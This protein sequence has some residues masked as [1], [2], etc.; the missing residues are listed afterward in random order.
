MPYTLKSTGLAT[1]L[2]ICVGIDSDGTTIKD[3]VSNRTLSYVSGHT[4]TVSSATWKGTSRGYFTTSGDGSFTPYGITF[5]AP[6]INYGGSGLAAFIAFSGASAATGSTGYDY[7][8]GDSSNS[9]GLSRTSLSGP[10][11]W[12]FS[13]NPQPG[14]GAT[15]LPTN[16][17]TKFSIGSSFLA[18][19]TITIYYGL[20]SGSLASDG[21]GTDINVPSNWLPNNIGG[22]AGL[23]AQPGNY[24]IA[25]AFNRVL[26]LAEMQ[27][28]HGDGTNDWFSTLFNSG[29]ADT[30][31]GQASL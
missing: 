22:D 26:T 1:S 19:G 23:G 24:H 8:I 28:L 3:F 18:G 25:C 17:T 20:E 31:M 12:C 5:T 16:G 27:S 11:S 21:S 10:L 2:V 4:P 9:F 13:G 7:A 6:T 30:L 15:S 29:A 14:T